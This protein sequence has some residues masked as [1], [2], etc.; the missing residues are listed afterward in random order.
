MRIDDR[1]GAIDPDRGRASAAELMALAPDVIFVDSAPVVAAMREQS[2]SVPIVFIQAGDPVQGGLVE[3]FAR[4]GGNL[5]GF[6]QYEPTMSAK[7]LQLL[8]D[9]A[10]NV[11]HIAVMQFD[12]STWRGDFS[13]IEAA[14]RSYAVSAWSR[15]SFHSDDEIERDDDVGA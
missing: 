11:T 14:A 8:K 4:P 15:R 9:I 6:L 2:G 3:S 13:V 7:F 10:P 1:W 5:T 12:H